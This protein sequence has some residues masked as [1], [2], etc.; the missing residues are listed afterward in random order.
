MARA[1]SDAVNLCGPF[2]GVGVT[3]SSIVQAGRRAT[4]KTTCVPSGLFTLVYG[5]WKML[6]K[7]H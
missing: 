1:E 3:G 2:E 6:K 7:C 4:P 5:C